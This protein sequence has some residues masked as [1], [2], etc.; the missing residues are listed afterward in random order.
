MT[1]GLPAVDAASA[2]HS[3][4]LVS[5]IEEKIAGSG[6]SIGFDEFMQHALYAPGLGYYVAGSR[7]FGAAGDFVTSPE[8][9]PLFANVLGRQC[10]QLLSGCPG[11]S[12]LEIGAGSGVMALQ[13]LHKLHDLDAMPEQYL[14]LEPSAEL[15]SR[16]QMLLAT[17]LPAACERV[18]WID[19]WPE[20]FR[21]IVVANEV[22][23]ALP[24]SRFVVRAGEIRELRVCTAAGG[25]FSWI[26]KEAHSPLLDAVRHIESDLGRQLPD[27][28]R[29]EVCLALQPW[30]A[31]L[32]KSISEGIVFLFDYG[33]SRAEYYAQERNTGWLRCHFRHRAHDD[34]LIYPGIQDLTSWVDF[35]AVASA[36]S[37][38]GL[39]VA[40]YTS[41]AQFLLNGGLALELEGFSGLSAVQQADLSRQVKLLTLPGEMGES[42]KCIG[43]SRGDAFG[44]TVFDGADRAHV[45]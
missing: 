7:K 27:G 24:V 4:K 40:G 19:R 30:I 15:Q 2:A 33:V 14:V 41:Q 32:A 10:A 18:K 1:T 8:I 6:G 31:D 42:F 16:Q 23:D 25:K 37:N 13:L 44:T 3:S 36:A 22:M 38:S 35:S 34:P 12:V 39:D 29:S 20:D 21:G 9:S 5:F 45:L 17:E 26:E 28:Y 11:S 43:L